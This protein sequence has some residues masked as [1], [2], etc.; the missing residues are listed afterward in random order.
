M[1]TIL[2][3]D[4]IRRVDRL[5]LEQ[6]GMSGL[7]LME[8]A[9]RNAAEIIESVYGP[10]GSA[11]LFCGGGNNGG[12]GC[13]IA[14]HLSNRGWSVRLVMIADA[15]KMT[16]DTAANYRVITAMGLHLVSALDAPSQMRALAAMGEKDVL[17]DAILGT[18]FHGEVRHPVAGLLQ[19]M[20]RAP[21]RAIVSIDVPSG[22]DCDS[23]QPSEATVRADL[24]ITFVALKQ[25][26][27][28]GGAP[29]ILGRVEVADI[30]VPTQLI[31][32][33]A[34]EGN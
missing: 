22:F 25:G 24:T 11:V 33:V 17:V 5:A 2:S 21:K 6:Y 23:G 26:Y 18:G 34:A 27:A 20:N 31:E 3:R 30:G 12:D 13:V 15:E 16:P 28:A 9:G 19:A 29:A 32:D 7:V 4:Q 1:P 8:N 10:A 14:R